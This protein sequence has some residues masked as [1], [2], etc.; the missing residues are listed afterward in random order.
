ML[1]QKSSANYSLEIENVSANCARSCSARLWMS[2]LC[3]AHAETAPSGR[4]FPG[5]YFCCSNKSASSTWQLLSVNTNR[6]P[7]TTTNWKIEKKKQTHILKSITTKK[8]NNFIHHVVDRMIALA[9]CALISF[10]VREYAS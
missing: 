6:P 2:Q 10:W 9:T 3:L 8:Q 7:A 5:D 1:W 4:F